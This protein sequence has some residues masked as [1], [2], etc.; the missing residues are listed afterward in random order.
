MQVGPKLW[1]RFSVYVWRSVYCQRSSVQGLGYIFGVENL[2][3]G[4]SE[5]L[6]LIRV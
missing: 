4:R 5:K 2:I 6:R 3:E 1:L